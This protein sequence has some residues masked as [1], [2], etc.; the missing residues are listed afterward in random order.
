MLRLL[1]RGARPARAVVAG[2]GLDAVRRATSRTGVYHRALTALIEGGRFARVP[3][4][5]Y[6]A[7]TSP[8]LTTAMVEFLAQA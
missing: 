7:M 2:Q 6:S 1:A 4:N 8:E 5:H 3:G